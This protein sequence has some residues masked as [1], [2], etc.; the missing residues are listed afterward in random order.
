M[1][2]LERYEARQGYLAEVYD[3]K[4]YLED[5]NFEEMEHYHEYLSH[6][7][8]YRD[9]YPDFFAQFKRLS[10]LILDLFLILFLLEPPSAFA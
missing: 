8:E 1:N 9:A 2:K 4:L 6:E 3:F 10:L 5:F 7:S